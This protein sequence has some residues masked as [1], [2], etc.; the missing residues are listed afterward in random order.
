MVWPAVRTAVKV[1]PFAIEIARQLDRHLRPHVLA[2]RLAHE[3]DG[4]VAAWTSGEG[5]H[6]I[7]FARPNADP[8]RAFPPVAP[9]ELELIGREIDRTTLRHH[10][11]LPEAK[12]RER[13]SKVVH[14]PGRVVGKR[15]RRDD[16]GDPPAPQLGSPSRPPH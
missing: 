15:R 1:A 16:H 10:R 6:W 7:V 14:A 2:Y 5:A 11:D 12:L 3:V 4:Y 8:I 9:G 13:T